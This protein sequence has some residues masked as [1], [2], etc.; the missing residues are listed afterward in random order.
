METKRRPLVSLTLRSDCKSEDIVFR[1][2]N[3]DEFVCDSYYLC[4]DS[5]YEARWKD[6]LWPVY[7]R[8]IVRD[9]LV[10]WRNHIGALPDGDAITLPFDLSDQCSTF[11][12]CRRE[13]DVA[14]LS[15][16]GSLFEGWGVRVSDISDVIRD[17]AVLRGVQIPAEHAALLLDLVADLDSIIASLA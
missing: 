17:P 5:D 7:Q 10:Q 13:G 15:I 6:Q 12:R 16:I 3:G 1:F 4:I 2:W 11:L 9:L 14:F 8:L